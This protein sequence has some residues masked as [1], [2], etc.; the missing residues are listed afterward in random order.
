[1]SQLHKLGERKGGDPARLLV[2][3]AHDVYRLLVACPT[4]ALA[5]RLDALRRDALAGSVTT[6]AV[7][8]PAELFVDPGGTRAVMAGRAEVGVGSPDTA[9]ACIHKRCLA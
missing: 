4:T 9:A 2:K 1:M 5:E 3:D 7:A 8:F 6:Q